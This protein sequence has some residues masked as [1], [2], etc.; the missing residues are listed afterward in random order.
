MKNFMLYWM[1]PFQTQKEAELI[2]L[3]DALEEEFSC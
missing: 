3:N 2:R 1:N